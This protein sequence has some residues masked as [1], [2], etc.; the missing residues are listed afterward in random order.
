MPKELT[1]A[2]KESKKLLGIYSVSMKLYQICSNLLETEF[3]PAVIYFLSIFLN[4]FN[5]YYPQCYNPIIEKFISCLE[6]SYPIKFLLAFAFYEISKSISKM[7]ILCAT[8]IVF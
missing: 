4:A 1:K 8:I 5:S 7:I 6:S 3:Y 2:L